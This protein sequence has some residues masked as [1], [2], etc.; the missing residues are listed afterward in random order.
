MCM[1]CSHRRKNWAAHLAVIYL[2]L[3]HLLELRPG[4]GVAAL[5]AM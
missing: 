1:S 5:R 4:E 2:E 3:F